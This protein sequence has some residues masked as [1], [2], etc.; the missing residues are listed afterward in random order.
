MFDY[1]DTIVVIVKHAHGLF[2]VEA[3]Q[4]S[5]ERVVVAKETRWSDA[6]KHLAEARADRPVHVQCSVSAMRA[7]KKQV[8]P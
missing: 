4:L 6:K 2:I 7:I 1:A 8:A 5:G 3:E